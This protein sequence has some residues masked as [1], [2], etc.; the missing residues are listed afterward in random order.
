MEAIICLLL[1]FFPTLIFADESSVIW[2]NNDQIKHFRLVINQLKQQTT[3]PI[4][5]PAKIPTSDPNQNLYASLSSLDSS[6]HYK[7]AWQINVDATE[8]CQGMKICNIGYISAEKNC[9]FEKTYSTMPDNKPHDKESVVLTDNLSAYYTP[10]HVGADSANPTLEWQQKGICYRISWRVY[11]DPSI[12]K[13]VLT[14]IGSSA[15]LEH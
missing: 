15:V 5:F 3:I 13:E 1:L 9:H 14:K 6:T 4:L 7:E 10:F 11:G 2:V 8:D 12:Q